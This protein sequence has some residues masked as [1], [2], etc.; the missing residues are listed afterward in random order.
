[1]LFRSE[2]RAPEPE[3]PARIRAATEITNAFSLD[4]T[5]SIHGAPGETAVFEVA[6]LQEPQGEFGYTL[7]VQTGETSLLDLYRLRRGRRK[8]VYGAR[9][10]ANLGDGSPHRLVWRQ[11]PDGQVQVLVDDGET[12]SL[13]DR[14]FRE[15]YDRLEL[16]NRAGELAVRDIT[17]LGTP[18]P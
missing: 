17:V 8:L 9:P 14:A 6:L 16:I 3:G 4:L 18:S 2:Q 15:G 11:A 12:M 7:A 13:R 5:F 10:E 1:M